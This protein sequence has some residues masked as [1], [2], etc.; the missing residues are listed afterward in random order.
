MGG[1]GEKQIFCNTDVSQKKIS[2][3]QR[4][5]ENVKYSNYLTINPSN[6]FFFNN[7]SSMV[8]MSRNGSFGQAR[9]VIA[10]SV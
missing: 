1:G 4:M 7:L 3:S 8:N 6:L 2:M 10:F 5:T 9:N